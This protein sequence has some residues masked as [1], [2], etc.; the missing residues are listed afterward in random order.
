MVLS[1][2][3]LGVTDKSLYPSFCCKC[4][5][6]IGWSREEGGEEYAQIYCDDC[7]KQEGD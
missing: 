3:A 2:E 5:Y 1:A 7:A 6:R 4:G